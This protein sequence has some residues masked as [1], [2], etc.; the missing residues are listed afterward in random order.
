MNSTI[1]VIFEPLSNKEIRLFLAGHS[2]VGTEVSSLM[3]R[4]TVEVPLGKEEHFKTLLSESDI[5]RSV[6]EPVLEGRP[7]RKFIPKSKK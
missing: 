2:L 6:S 3:H 5:V 4:Y 7:R 1:F